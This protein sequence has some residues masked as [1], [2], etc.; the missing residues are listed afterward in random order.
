MATRK[1]RN[2]DE[3]ELRLVLPE[4]MYVGIK[5]MAKAE[6][7]TMAKQAQYL[8]ELGAQFHQMQVNGQIETQEEQPSELQEAIGFK[9][10]E[11]EEE[12]EEEIEEVE[13]G[14]TVAPKPKAKKKTSR[15][16][17]K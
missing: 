13:E 15:S 9:L 7:R 14:K 4:E 2:D 16:K 17:N 3:R 5:T 1:K 6:L 8:I 11:P 12:E 10:E